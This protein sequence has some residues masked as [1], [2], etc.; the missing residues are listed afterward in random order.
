MSDGTALVVGLGNAGPA[1]VGNRHNVGALV[2]DVLADRA[3]GRFSVHKARGGARSEVVQA[4][5]SERQVVLA[6][7]LSYMNEVGGPV[8]GLC[9][10]FGVLPA[11]LVV[12]HDELDLP[13]GAVRGKFGGGDNGHNGLRSL[14]RSLGMGDYL[15]VRVGIG[16]PPGR[17]SPADFVLRDFSAAERKELD[18]HLAAAAD[19]AEELLDGADPATVGRSA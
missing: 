17:Q 11:N 9:A 16:R 12:V 3:G 6:K 4:R 7:P 15:R 13:Y 10:Y 14:R 2:A 1:Y 19:A 8:A 18:L 5:L